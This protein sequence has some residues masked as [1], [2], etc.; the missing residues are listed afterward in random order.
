MLW[1]AKFVRDIHYILQLNYSF[2]YL[3][4]K[5]DNFIIFQNKIESFV[6][7]KNI[8]LLQNFKINMVMN[9]KYY[10]LSL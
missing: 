7:Q 2:I 4:I 6:K 3:L 5:K 10:L 1:S 9:D 8:G